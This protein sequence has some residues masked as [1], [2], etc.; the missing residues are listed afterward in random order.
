[1]HWADYRDGVK[2]AK[3]RIGFDVNRGIP[4][5]VYLTD[6]KADEWPFGSKIVSRGQTGIYDR[7]YQCHR[8]FDEWQSQG[9][10][11]VCRIVLVQ[12]E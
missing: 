8:N 10:H 7:Y 2:K 12:R 11:Y 4:Q 3:A 6:G 1:M 5:K 9:R